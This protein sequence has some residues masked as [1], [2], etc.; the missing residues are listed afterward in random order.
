MR[1]NAN[2]VKSAGRQW[3][4]ANTNFRGLGGH[5]GWTENLVFQKPTK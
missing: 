2:L 4:L 1:D 3:I 5:V